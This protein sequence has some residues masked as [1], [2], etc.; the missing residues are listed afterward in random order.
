MLL[1]ERTAHD[2]ERNFPIRVRRLAFLRAPLGA[3]CPVKPGSQSKAKERTM[4]MQADDQANTGSNSSLPQPKEQP[5]TRA[6]LRSITAETE[7]LVEVTDE[8]VRRAMVGGIA[9]R[10]LRESLLRDAWRRAQGQI[11]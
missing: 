10:G 5:G 3:F 4:T 6:P 9:P 7:G 11:R 1:H 8:D 2:R